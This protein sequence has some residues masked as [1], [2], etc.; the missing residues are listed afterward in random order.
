MSWLPDW[1]TGF[2]SANAE[3]AA[4]DDAQLQSL[5]AQDF[6]P[7]GKDYTPQNAAIV[8][9]QRKTELAGIG[10]SFDLNSERNAIQDAF[11]TTLNDQAQSIFGRFFKAVGDILKSILGTIP[12]WLWLIIGAALFFYF[13]GGRLLRR[14]IK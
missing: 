10:G 5:N 6:G 1:L 3:K 13:G 7:G 12:W 4:A 8:A 11:D 9:N 2:D 14:I